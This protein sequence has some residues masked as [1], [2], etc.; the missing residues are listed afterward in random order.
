MKFKMVFWGPDEDPAGDRA[1]RIGAAL[2]VGQS[3]LCCYEYSGTH[4][5]R[6]DQ[7]ADGRV[8]RTPV[9]NFW[10]RIVSDIVR[11]DGV[12]AQ[13]EF[14]VEVELGECLVAF[15]MPAAE[16][17]RMGWV[18]RKLGPQAIIYPG[19]QQHARAA[20]QWLSGEIP[21]DYIFSHLGW[22]KHGCHR[23]YLHAA[24]ALGAD[25]IVSGLEVRVPAVLR[26]YQVRSIQ[27]PQ[28][29]NR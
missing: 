1:P 18:L 25:G 9:A 14:G 2:P 12:R 5:V 16:F 23:V 13:R 10:A 19:Q 28:E 15:T 3:P 21:Q 29:M 6:R 4:M 24:G 27:D 8:R 20:I 17:G 11:D 22:R 26:S 7:L